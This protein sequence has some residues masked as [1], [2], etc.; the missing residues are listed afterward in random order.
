MA[1]RR[2]DPLAAAHLGS[3]HL[4]GRHGTAV[5][6]KLALFWTQLAV[7]INNALQG[8]GNASFFHPLSAETVGVVETVVLP[9]AK[10]T[11]AS[12]PPPPS[13]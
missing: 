1:A 5:D 13:M 6:P 4:E 9:R 8:S 3:F 12:V 2:G 7:N 11:C 10:R